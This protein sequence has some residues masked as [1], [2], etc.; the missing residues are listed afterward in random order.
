MIVS[1]DIVKD[2]MPLYLDGVCS[3]DSKAAVAAHIVSCETCNAELLAMQ[4]EIPD[5]GTEQN[6]K[7]AEAVIKLSRRWK[8]SMTKSLLK[9]ILFT[10]LTVAAVLLVM[11]LFMDI[12]IVY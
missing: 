3:N 1:C 12:R 2:L 11:Y 5:G 10:T 9:G 6:L 4:T 8:K 7:E